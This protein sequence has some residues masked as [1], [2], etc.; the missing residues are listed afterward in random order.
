[1]SKIN[2][3]QFT[4]IS[5]V[6]PGAVSQGGY[7]V[8]HIL[9]TGH[10]PAL[11]LEKNERVPNPYRADD[12]GA[13]VLNA[14]RRE[15]PGQKFDRFQEHRTAINSLRNRLV[16]TPR[17]ID[18]I[19]AEP[20]L[21]THTN[22]GPVASEVLLYVQKLGQDAQYDMLKHMRGKKHGHDI[23]TLFDSLPASVREADI[24][25]QYRAMLYPGDTLVFKN[26]FRPA[27]GEQREL[28]THK[29]HSVDNSGSRVDVARDIALGYVKRVKRESRGINSAMKFGKR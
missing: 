6:H 1:M 17:H 27:I 23:T 26:G 21:Q 24:I 29:F 3:V 25:G 12:I 7:P 8:G 4:D 13:I 16:D 20:F 18:G 11:V 28:V 22:H 15:Y 14:V 9:A 2:T 10:E 19:G 5:Q